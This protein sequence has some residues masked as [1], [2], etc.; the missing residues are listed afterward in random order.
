MLGKGRY[1]L[2]GVGIDPIYLYISDLQ[3]FYFTTK[4]LIGF[5]KQTYLDLRDKVYGSMSEWLQS[6]IG[7]SEEQP[8]ASFHEDFKATIMVV[9]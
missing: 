6:R 2:K 1:L 4:S 8:S 5:T 3:L 7:T 9:R